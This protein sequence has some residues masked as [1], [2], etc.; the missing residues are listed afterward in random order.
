LLED[1]NPISAVSIVRLQAEAVL[2]GVWILFAASDGWIQKFSSDPKLPQKEPA[3]FPRVFEM[4]NDLPNSPADPILH[5]SLQGLK[6]LAWDSLN[7]YTH[8][9][10]R[11]VRRAL[12]GFD[13][14]LL[15]WMLRTANSLTYI[16]A[17]LLAFIAKDA[18][19][20]K[21]LFEI[22]MSMTDCLH[23]LQES[24]SDERP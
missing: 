14:D 10:L 20:S 23:A 17:Q 4:L 15:L 13:D 5:Q 16:A 12:E 7:S 6:D 2:R 9:G 1:Q 3:E 24:P 21:K 18:V 8:G 11:L 19:G 22:R